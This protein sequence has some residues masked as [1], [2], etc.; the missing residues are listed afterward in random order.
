MEAAMDRSTRCQGCSGWLPE[1]SEGR[2]SS[3]WVREVDAR[4]KEVVTSWWGKGKVEE[5]GDDESM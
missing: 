1:P 4:C 3:E 5:E 2:R